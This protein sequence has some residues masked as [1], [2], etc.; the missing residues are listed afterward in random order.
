[1]ITASKNSFSDDIVVPILATVGFGAERR[2]DCHCE[3]NPGI[4]LSGLIK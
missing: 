2:I 1:M 4:E 3:A